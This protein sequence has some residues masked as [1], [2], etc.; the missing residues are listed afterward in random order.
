ML[1][2]LLLFS[3]LRMCVLYI[4]FISGYLWVSLWVYFEGKLN[5][6]KFSPLVPKIKIRKKETFLYFFILINWYSL[7]QRWG[8]TMWQYIGH[9]DGYF[10]EII[11]LRSQQP[12]HG[13]C[14]SLCFKNP[15][16]PRFFR[17]RK[18]R[19]QISAPLSSMLPLFFRTWLA[20]RP[21]K[22]FNEEEGCR[23]QNR[24]SFSWKPQSLFISHTIA[25]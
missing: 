11:A 23:I 22:E 15:R 8:Q 19:K 6:C 18:E 9:L 4:L 17:Y 1:H 21:Q 24:I 7:F 20:P 13:I 16:V 14:F 10:R 25:W 3:S 12:A 2:I 5:C